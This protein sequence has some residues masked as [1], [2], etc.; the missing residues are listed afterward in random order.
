MKLPI[1]KRMRLSASHQRSKAQEAE[2]AQ[3]FGGR[4]SKQSGAGYQK[5]D[6]RA[7]KFVRVENK[8][9]KH[10][11]FRVTVDMIEK[12]EADAFGADEIPLL[13]VELLLGKKRVF[14]IPD[15]AIEAVLDAIKKS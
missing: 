10:A 13:E 5:A 15:Y 7:Y 6:V 1:S 3:R 14:V 12:L 2:T 11:S 8:T 4:V 9:T